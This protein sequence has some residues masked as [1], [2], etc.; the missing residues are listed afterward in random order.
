MNMRVKEII[1]K[2]V[3]DAAGDNLGK[4]EDIEINWTNSAVEHFIIKG[5]PEIK[6]KLM[7]SKYANQLLKKIGAKADPDI[8]ISFSDVQSIGD[9]ITLKI[10]II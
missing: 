4:V 3:I 5:D 1:G 6:Q 9:V 10:D 7:S 2:T 8:V